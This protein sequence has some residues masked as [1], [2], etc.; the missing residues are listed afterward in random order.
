MI[1]LMKHGSQFLGENNFGLEA[2]IH[3]YA[4][5][6]IRPIKPYVLVLPVMSLLVYANI[7]WLKH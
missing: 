7:L 1:S 4:Y 5:K 2:K 6:I 3:L